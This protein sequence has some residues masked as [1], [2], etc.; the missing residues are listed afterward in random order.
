MNIPLIFFILRISSYSI[1]FIYWSVFYMN[2]N[3][4]L[5]S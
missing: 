1:F 3:I 2:R 4:I 5:I